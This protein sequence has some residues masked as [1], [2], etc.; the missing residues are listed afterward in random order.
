MESAATGDADQAY[1]AVVSMSHLHARGI[2]NRLEVT[3]ANTSPES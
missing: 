2:S 3:S 1:S